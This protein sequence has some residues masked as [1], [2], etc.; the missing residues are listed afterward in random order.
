MLELPFFYMS[1]DYVGYDYDDLLIMN[2]QYFVDND[3]I[4]ID[5][6]SKK[7]YLEGKYI[8]RYSNWPT[9]LKYYPTFKVSYS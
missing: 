5:Y 9:N 6:D 3:L 2:N 8:S 4:L 7:L 1:K